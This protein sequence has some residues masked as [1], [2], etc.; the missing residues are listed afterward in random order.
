MKKL[1]FSLFAFLLLCASPLSTFAQSDVSASG[2]YFSV[3]PIFTAGMSTYAG[4]VAE[5]YK[6]KPRFG[7]SV[8][9]FSELDFSQT[10]GM[11]LGLGYESR[12][13]Y[14]YRE[15]NESIENYT[16]ELGYLSITPLFNFRHFL[17]GFGFRLPMSGTLIVDRANT[18]SNQELPYTN[19]STGEIEMT[20]AI[21]FK[22]GGNIELLETTGG[23][24][25]F[26]VLAGYDLAPPFKEVGAPLFNPAGPDAS[27]QIGL[28]YLFNAA[29]LP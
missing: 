27:L 3:G 2:R 15:A 22:I 17:L 18:K 13:R 19:A 4:D 14:W 5:T 10:A 7:F 21:D 11:N 1:I 29:A 8:G 25:N 20:T 28:N 12:A 26:I 23:I 9:I 16:A 24:L 6:I